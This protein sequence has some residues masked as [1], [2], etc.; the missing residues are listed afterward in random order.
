[1]DEFELIDRYFT[2][3]AAEADVLLG[4]GDDGAIVHPAAGRELV[5]V[6]DTLV[7][8]VHFPSAMS[9]ADIGYR[10]VVVNVSDIAAMAGR[11]RW[12][13]LA[14]TLTDANAQWLQ[15]FSGGLFEAAREY[16]LALIGGDTTRG[17]EIVVTVQVIGDVAA[18]AVLRRSGA[19]EGDDIYV[20][21]TAGDAAAGLALLSS[22]NRQNESERYLCRR[23]TR[24]AARIQ[25]ASKLAPLASAAI[26]LSD[27]LFGDIGKL[28]AASRAGGQIDVE[29]LPLSQQ[30]I[31]VRGSDDAIELALGGG[32]DYEIAFTAAASQAGAIR[33]LADQCSLRVT[34]IG[35]VCPGSGLRCRKNNRAFEF[36]TAG[37]LHFSG[38]DNG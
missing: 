1:M 23:F 20:T 12:M 13:T 17:K 16:S 26:D 9:P 38:T 10:A 2:Q 33:E 6:T 7:E 14:L 25:F 5:I 3:D 37:Y 19:T 31:A 27:G 8:G 34:R 4:I 24:P 30:L 28:L 22:G 35:E 21:G 29:C 15:E 18:D 36:S 32:D 11:P